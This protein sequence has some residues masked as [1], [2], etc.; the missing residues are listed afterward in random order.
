MNDGAKQSIGNTRVEDMNAAFVESTYNVARAC[1]ESKYPRLFEGNDS[2]RNRSWK[3][4]TWSKKVREENR[5]RRRILGPHNNTHG[6]TAA[7]SASTAARSASTAARSA[8][9]A[10]TSAANWV[11]VTAD[12]RFSITAVNNLAAAAA[13]GTHEW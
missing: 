8:S 6:T 12:P 3:V 5:Q 13:D 2:E 10:A 1:L 9:T 7:R 4:A 11:N